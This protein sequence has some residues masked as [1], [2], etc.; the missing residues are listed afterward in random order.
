MPLMQ[1]FFV[2]LASNLT[3]EVYVCF[4][5]RVHLREDF[6]E[7]IADGRQDSSVGRV[8][9]PVGPQGDVTEQPR[10]PLTPQ[11]AQHVGAV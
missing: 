4:H 1:C 8:G 11:L 3:S 5:A 2:S 7:V 9:S 6:L 10:L